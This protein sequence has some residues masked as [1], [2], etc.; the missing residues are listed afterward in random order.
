MK[1][2]A[3]GDAPPRKK[4]GGQ[5]GNQNARKHGHYAKALTPE[6][7]EAFPEVLKEYYL[8]KEIAVLRLMIVDL[9]AA[10]DPDMKL[11]LRSMGT[12]SRLLRTH[13]YSKS[14]L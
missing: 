7:L 11:I 4:S 5:P 3:E 12:L 14:A 6:Q 8:D 1:Q 9:K 10:P 2:R 13:Y